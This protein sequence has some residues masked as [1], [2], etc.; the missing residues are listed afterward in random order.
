MPTPLIVRRK[1]LAAALLTAG[2]LVA[3]AVPVALAQAPA[4]A[5]APK[6]PAA[7]TVNA[8]IMVMHAT[9][10]DGGPGWIDPAIGKVPQLTKPPF[11]AYNTY[12]LLDK[13]TLPLAINTPGTYSL[14]N[15]RVLQVTFLDAT[16][17]KRFHI[18]TAINQPGG[19]AY[20]KLLEVTAAPNETFFVGGQSYQGGSIVLG[21]TM[22][23]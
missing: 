17:D 8:E 14:P 4:Q 3:G 19:T 2:L 7:L 11:S 6:G 22:R 16:V 9:Q 1:L 13:R 15:G 5:Q 12:K 10:S 20:L 23:P 18:K 21:I